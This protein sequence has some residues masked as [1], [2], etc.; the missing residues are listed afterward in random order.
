MSEAIWV[1]K[2]NRIGADVLKLGEI[3][4]RT[5]IALSR[6]SFCPFSRI[7]GWSKRQC[8]WGRYE[9]SL[10]VPPRFW[11]LEN[12]YSPRFVQSGLP[13]ATAYEGC[14]ISTC[15]SHKTLKKSMSLLIYK[16]NF[17]NDHKIRNSYNSHVS[18]AWL[19]SSYVY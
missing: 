3:L 17:P 7:S 5:P 16:N 18:S 8:F 9:S 6:A 11:S 14:M 2:A 4:A 10:R 1:K 13:T 15:A 12:Q 19:T